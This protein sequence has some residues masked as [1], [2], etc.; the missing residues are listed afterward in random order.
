MIL[1]KA[2][3]LVALGGALGSAGRYG[4]MVAVGRVFGTGFP[5]G[6][7][8]VNV[9]GSII[10]GVLVELVALRWSMTEGMRLFL[11]VGVLGGFT[12]FSTFS[13]DVVTLLNRGAV[14]PAALYAGASVVVCVVGVYGGLHL[15]R[16]SLNI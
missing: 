10:M 13:L 9:L 5:W 6:T 16:W 14:V 4:M 11:F 12:T 8:A 3:A 7:L 1:Y 15:V 2:M